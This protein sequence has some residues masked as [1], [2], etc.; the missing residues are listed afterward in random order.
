MGGTGY[1]PV[2]VGDSPTETEET[3]CEVRDLGSTPTRSPFRPAN[4]RAERA[5]R[6]CHPFG[7]EIIGFDR[8]VISQFHSI[9]FVVFGQQT[10]HVFGER[11]LTQPLIRLARTP[12]IDARLGEHFLVQIA[13]KFFKTGVRHDSNG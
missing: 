5:G 9:R 12:G 10:N 11:F 3:S 13:G 4:G 2:P 6:P 8:L 1:Q 7:Y